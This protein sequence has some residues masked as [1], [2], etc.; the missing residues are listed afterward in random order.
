MQR[1][2]TTTFV[3]KFCNGQW[4]WNANQ[5]R[6]EFEDTKDAELVKEDYVNTCGFNFS[7]TVNQLEELIF[8]QEFQR[9]DLTHDAD[10][11]LVQDIKNIVLFLAPS[12]IITTDF[13]HFLHTFTVDRFLRALIIYFEYYLKMVEFVLIRR[14]EIAGEK[15]QI[16]SEDTNEIKRVYSTH[17][18]QHRLL[19]AREYSTIIMGDGEMKGFYHITP[20][21]NI[22]HS[23]KDKRFHEAF[24]AFSTQVVW[25]A[26]HRRAYDYIDMEMY[27]LFRSEHFKLKRYAHINFTQAET[28]MLY[29][30][31]YK[32]RNYRA[33]NSPLIQEL[34]N[35]STENL[36]ILWI[37]ERKYRGTDLRIHQLELEY[38]VPD[39][40]LTL[41]DVCH[42]I[43]G[44]P[45]KIYDT[46]LTINWEAVRF[47]NYS[48]IYDPYQ[49]VRQPALKIPNV[50]EE[51]MRKYAQKFDTYYHVRMQY[52]R[53]S[54]ALIDKWCR[55]D[56]VIE[57][58]TEDMITSIITKCEKELQ[59]YSY[60][61]SVEEITNKFLTRKK[62]LRKL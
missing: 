18:I 13:I 6:I 40:Q 42:G 1:I 33:Q 17:L 38:I 23:I 28:S 29:G 56:A 53:V 16:Q 10:V 50:D 26:M 2:Y 5:E 52:E 59:R 4:V 46:V 48:E 21:V 11:I 62:L 39:S 19:L 31:N 57:C 15:A 20:I 34:A 30:K 24:L 35:V 61:P 22:S 37:G 43:L 7:K 32:R 25:I 8:R 54:K 58:F 12:E 3:P 47:Q 9:S 44:H 45:K 49:L 27:R 55:R 60:G 51:K 36:P 14:D 41:I